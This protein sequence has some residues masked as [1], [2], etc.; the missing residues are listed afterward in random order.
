MYDPQVNYVYNDENIEKYFNNPKIIYTENHL[1]PKLLRV[2]NK[3]FNP[4][5]MNDVVKKY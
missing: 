5:F 4:Y 2:D 1:K 3:Q